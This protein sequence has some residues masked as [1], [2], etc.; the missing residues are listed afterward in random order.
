MNGFYPCNQLA[1]SN[2]FP[3]SLDG[4]TSGNATSG[5]K[6]YIEPQHVYINPVPNTATTI[7]RLI[8]LRQIKRSFLAMDKDV[9][10]GVETFLRLQT[11]YLSQIGCYC[12]NPASIH[13]TYTNIT[14]TSVSM[15]NVNLYLALQM[16]VEI[17]DEV[18][19]AMLSGK[20]KFSIP[21]LYPYRASVSGNSSTANISTTVSR[22]YGRSLKEA[23]VVFYNAQ[24]FTPY[25]SDSNNTNGC[26]VSAYYTSLSNRPLQ[27][28]QITVYNPYSSVNPTGAGITSGMEFGLDY[29]ECQKW[30]QNSV[31]SSYPMMQSN[32]RWSDIWGQ[33]GALALDKYAIPFE[34]LN[35][36]LSLTDSSD[37]NYSINCPCGAS[38]SSSNNVYTNGMIVYFFFT[39]MRT[40]HCLP[41]GIELTI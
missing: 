22:N 33:P 17:R 40:L 11:A 14:S 1:S 28:R 12:T 8:P 20:M 21:Y 29:L 7:Y 3:W 26:K 19:K 30:R 41:N 23:M 6:S 16:N 15:S 25:V 32:S 2:V 5:I 13:T 31:L 34:N 9:C 4:L 10:F 18:V 36:G 24:E 35:D 27:D 39:F 38:T 37:W